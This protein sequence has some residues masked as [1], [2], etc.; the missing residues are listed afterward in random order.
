MDAAGLILRIE[1]F[2]REYPDTQYNYLVLFE[3]KYRTISIDAV[4][5]KT[6]F[7]KAGEILEDIA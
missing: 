1:V 3:K 4:E 6:E 7:Q 5:H 2:L